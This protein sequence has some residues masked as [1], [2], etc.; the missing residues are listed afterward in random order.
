[1]WILILLA[2]LCLIFVVTASPMALPG[3]LEGT[4]GEH[5]DIPEGC[6]CKFIKKKHI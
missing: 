3:I 4:F 6:F 1:M 2:A 5:G